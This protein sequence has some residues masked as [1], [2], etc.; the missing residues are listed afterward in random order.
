MNSVPNLHQFTNIIFCYQSKNIYTCCLFSYFLI[1]CFFFR[2]E[3]FFD[4][5]YVENCVLKGKLLP[6]LIDYR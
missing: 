3:D 4:I 1:N 5:K 6:N 2:D